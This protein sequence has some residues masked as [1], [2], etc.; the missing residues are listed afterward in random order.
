MAIIVS[1]PTFCFKKKGGWHCQ[2]S[3]VSHVGFVLPWQE[4]WTTDFMDSVVDFE[5]NGTGAAV[6]THLELTTGGR[7][8]RLVGIH[9]GN[10]GF[11]E[12]WIVG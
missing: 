3:I 12:A 4:H 1:K 9:E 2:S 11:K 8:R 5:E 10:G 6:G 7:G